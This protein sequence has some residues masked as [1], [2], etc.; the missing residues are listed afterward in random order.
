MEVHLLDQKGNLY[1][2]DLRVDFIERI[3]AE[4][5]FESA[6]ALVAQIA[7]DIQQTREVLQR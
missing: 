7:A 6:E 5:Q 1:E 4:R 2:Q 3:R